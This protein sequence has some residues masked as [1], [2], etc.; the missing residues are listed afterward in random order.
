MI[1]GWEPWRIGLT[2]FIGLASLF[3]D[4][5][6]D[7]PTLI[8]KHIHKKHH[9]WIAPIALAATYA[10]PLEHLAS[11]L[12]P[13]SVGPIL[14]NCHPVTLWTWWF[15]VISGTLAHHSGYHLPFLPSPEF[16]DFH[17]LKF[18]QNY[19]VLGVLDYLHGT[20]RVFRD[21]VASK[22]HK[23]F[24]NFEAPRQVFPDAKN[25]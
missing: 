24:F 12:I 1:A 10:H 17:H 7:T 3:K 20:D 15:V 5:K 25:H 18:N 9:E 11:S 6:A 16:H 13:A 8:N 23:T 19:G 4:S 14:T 2:F 21:H 22:R